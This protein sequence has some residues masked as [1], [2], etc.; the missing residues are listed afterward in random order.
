MHTDRIWAEFLIIL[1]KE[2]YFGVLH[3]VVHPL[4]RLLEE[5][6]LATTLQGVYFIF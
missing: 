3:A 1:T 6:S 4:S 2:F 5:L